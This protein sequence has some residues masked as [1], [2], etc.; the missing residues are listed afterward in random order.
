MR[1][2]ATPRAACGRAGA[3]LAWIEVAL[4]LPRGGHAEE[5][6]NALTQLGAAAITPIAADRAQPEA[7]Q[8]SGARGERLRRIAQEACKQ[9]GR[10]WLPELAQVQP[11]TEWLAAHPTADTIALA[12]EAP[13]T[14][15][16]WLED[17]TEA[18][19]S[20]WSEASPLRLVV[21]PE[22]GFSPAEEEG[23]RARGAAL[24]GLGPHT[25]R[26]ETAALAALAIAAERAFRSRRS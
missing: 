1:R 23:L 6:V 19:R 24:L 22:G 7:R 18:A 14:L 20:G 8:L 4:V 16:E 3:A 17:R 5:I 11:L 15:S 26:I 21:G 9:S 25:L 12:P 13:C 2:R 10:L